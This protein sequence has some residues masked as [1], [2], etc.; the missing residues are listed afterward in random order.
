MSSNQTKTAYYNKLNTDISTYFAITTSAIGIPLNLINIIVFTKLL[1][2]KTNMG[3]LCLCQAIID[4]FLLLDFFLLTRSSPLIF[5]QSLDSYSDFLCRFVK[6]MRR[7]PIHLSSWMNVIITFD[8][9]VF[10]LYGN[11][12][13][14]KFMKK[15]TSLAAIIIAIF[16]ALAI[17]D[18]PNLLYYLPARKVGIDGSLGPVTTCVATFPVLIS[19]DILSIVFRTYI[20]LGFMLFFNL[21]MVRKIF[22]SSRSSFRQTS[23]C[24]KETHF[25]FAVM[26]FDVY[27]F[28]LNFPLSVFY[29]IY[30]VNYYSGVLSSKSE[31]G[32][33]YSM[34]V[35]LMV[36][37]SFIVQTIS[38]IM[39]FAF[40]KVFRQTLLQ[41]VGIAFRIESFRR[42]YPST[43]KNS[44]STQTPTKIIRTKTVT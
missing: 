15:K 36:D 26:A 29:I 37:V 4:L 44:T 43:D 19:T 9:F 8:R 28:I 38:F 7:L 33:L 32:A 31:L 1:H 22:R 12:Q 13:K 21:L 3:F 20:P 23:L 40:N 34:I 25:T 14:F 41:L 10:I 27:F 2:Q 11:G 30:D 16:V 42:I 6:Y 17:L 35:G 5:P 18:I 39:N 24:R